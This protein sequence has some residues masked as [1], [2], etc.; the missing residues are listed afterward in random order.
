MGAAVN[1]QALGLIAVLISHEQLACVL[2]GLWRCRVM[3]LLLGLTEWEAL[4]GTS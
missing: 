4:I 1:G 3:V 2:S